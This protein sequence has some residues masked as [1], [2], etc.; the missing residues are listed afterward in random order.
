MNNSREMG[1]E[2]DGVLVNLCSLSRKEQA[3]EA[4]PSDTSLYC[5]HRIITEYLKVFVGVQNL[6]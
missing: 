5:I 3:Q 2:V 4:W 6:Q 1:I